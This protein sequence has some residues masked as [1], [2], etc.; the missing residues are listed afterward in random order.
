MSRSG[1]FDRPQQSDLVQRTIH[2][3]ENSDW[4]SVLSRPTDIAGQDRRRRRALGRSVQERARALHHHAQC[5]HRAACARRLHHLDRDAAR[6]ARSGRRGILHLGHHALH[7][8]L[9]HRHGGRQS[10]APDAGQPHRLCRRRAGVRRGIGRL[11]PRPDHGAAADRARG[12]GIGRRRRARPVDE[13]DQRIVPAASAQARAGAGLR[14]LGRR[15]A[16]R[17]RHR[18]PVRV[19]GILARRVLDQRA[20]RAAVRAGLHAPAEEEGQRDRDPLSLS[21]AGVADRRRGGGGDGEPGRAS[22]GAGRIAGGGR[23]SRSR[24]PSS[25]TR[26]AT[27]ACSP[28]IRCRW[29]GRSGRRTG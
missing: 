28:A 9:H 11:R 12:A 6:G 4:E 10:G 14:R 2:F 16:A 15:L 26:P 29:R 18:R 27:T 8:R 13:P 25:S 19:G 20:D 3:G 24:S 5:R 7:G 21:A 23:R 1:R 22:V 17:P